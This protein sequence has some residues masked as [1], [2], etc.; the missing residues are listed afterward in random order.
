[1]SQIQPQEESR[2]TVQDEVFFLLYSFLPQPI[3]TKV[4]PHLT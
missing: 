1:M 2:S 4:V 3:L